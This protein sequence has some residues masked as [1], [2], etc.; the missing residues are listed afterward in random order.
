MTPDAPRGNLGFHWRRRVLWLVVAFA[1]QRAALR[2]L[3]RFQSR[4]GNAIF[5]ASGNHTTPQLLSPELIVHD[6]A[7]LIFRREMRLAWKDGWWERDVE[8]RED[9]PM[10]R[11]HTA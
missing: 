5:S 11:S 8:L 7:Q 9:P 6:P 10:E 4:Y 3:R 1:E 2:T